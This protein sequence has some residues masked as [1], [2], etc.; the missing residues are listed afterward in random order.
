MSRAVSTAR[1]RC[2]YCYLIV[3]NKWI[4]AGS[5]SELMAICLQAPL[6]LSL[7]PGIPTLPRWRG[8]AVRAHRCG[9]CF[10]RATSEPPRSGSFDLAVRLDDENGIVEGV[11]RALFTR[12][13][14]I[15]VRYPLPFTL[16]AE[17][18]NGAWTVVEAGAGLL[19]GDVVRACSTLEFR[20]D[21]ARSE[22]RCGS[23]FRGRRPPRVEPSNSSEPQRWWQ[24]SWLFRDAEAELAGFRSQRPTRVLFVVDGKTPAEVSDAFAAN[25]IDRGVRD[26][27]MLFERPISE[28]AWWWLGS[29]GSSVGSSPVSGGLASNMQQTSSSSAPPP[30]FVPYDKD[31]DDLASVLGRLLDSQQPSGEPR[32]RPPSPP[33]SGGRSTN[34]AR[35]GRGARRSGGSGARGRGSRRGGGGSSR[36]NRRQS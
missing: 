6:L 2:Y 28:D 31:E 25:E 34:G 35:R 29:P 9:P 36:R 13:T 10:G 23:G 26:I 12:S 33:S 30:P 22:V 11:L 19:V 27:V 16:E 24:P 5:H 3:H 7:L 14:L 4:V 8:A 15:T 20:Y 1:A 18:S 32:A 17:Y 21:S